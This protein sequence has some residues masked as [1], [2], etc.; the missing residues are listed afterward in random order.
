MKRFIIYIICVFLI[1]VSA[2]FGRQPINEV[3]D[4]SISWQPLENN[5]LGKEQSLSVL[6]IKNNG[7][8][9]IPASG[10][11][12]YFNFVRIFNPK[13][14][15]QLLNSKH[16][17]G[18]LFYFSPSANFKGLKPG[19]SIRYEMVSNSWLVNIK[20]AP[21]GFYLV[22]DNK[23]IEPLGQVNILKP[24]D[25]QKF[26]RVGGDR[27]ISAEM[28]F[29][30]NK[31]IEDI[32]EKELTKIF[33]TPTFYQENSGSFTINTKTAIVYDHAFEKEVQL[34]KSDLAQLLGRNLSTKKSLKGSK[35]IINIQKDTLSN[36][37]YQLNISPSV[38]SIKA[39]TTTGIFYA[40]QSLKTLIHPSVYASTNN[41]T[42][43]VKAVTVKDNPRFGYRA[44]MLDVARNFQSKAQIKKILDLM[45]L[46]KLNTLHFHLN[47]DEGW[48][49]EIPALPELT[50]VGSKRGHIFEDEETTLPPSYGS[51]PFKDKS[52][53]SGYY[54]KNDFIEILRYAAE[55]HIIVIP[56][57]ET[58][59]HA[60]SAI[61]AMFTR[62]QRLMKEGKKEEAEKYLLHDFNDQSVYRSVQKWNDNVINVAMPSVYNFL[63]V[64]TDEVI[65]MY[66]EANV[67]LNTIHFGGDEV[68]VGVW[69]QSPAFERLK[70][71][72]LS[73]KNTEDLWNYFFNK[74]DVMLKSKGL[75][76]SGWEEVALH[77]ITVDGKKKWMPNEYFKN[78]N[79]RVNVWNNLLGNEDLA[80]R[81]ANSGYK[82]ILSFVSNFYFDMAYHKK[83]EEPGFYWGGFAELD[84]PFSFIPFDYLKNQQKDYLG[85][86]LSNKVLTEAEKLTDYGKTNIEGIQGL[87]WSETVKNEAQMEYLMLPRLLALAERAWSKNPTW[88]NEVDSVKAHQDYT[89]D[90]SQFFNLI[91]KR[92]LKRLDYY[93][94]GFNYR[95]PT[96]GLKKI[97]D[98]INANCQLPG[99]SIRYTTDGSIPTLE[100]P[101][102]Q[103]PLKFNE[104]LIFRTFNSRGRGSS[105][106][107]IE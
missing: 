69:E 36:E 61:K 87:L 29:D 20:D 46:Y 74:V 64:V 27:E 11:K 48:R 65:A 23:K 9:V 37:A 96:P 103:Q 57:I 43:V 1:E 12:L 33:P 21:Q 104:H 35:N 17:N 28:I 40:I 26:F 55:R 85:R 51:G 75:Y 79:I 76:L 66:E 39:G 47:D 6:E 53:G 92:E 45:A 102:Y 25:D 54:T 60:R 94:G 90:L 24:L 83:F 89:K 63:E 105:V 101:L 71:K 32:P 88:A 97:G 78:R 42:I 34:L 4:L 18:D 3:A 81:L 44:L 56:E 31:I 77:K 98:T 5:Y 80:Y 52:S 22:W 68:P 86:Q 91:G 50:T 14:E 100:S 16:V 59:G 73:I 19:E 82:V 67:T 84:K 72:E 106:S 8:K 2:V 93:A 62:Y 10:W 7:S 15:N 95:I 70:A 107:Q 38:I 49:L 41:K 30:Q 99:F 58:P 13:S